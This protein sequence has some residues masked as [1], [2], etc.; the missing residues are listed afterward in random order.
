MLRSLSILAASAVSA[1][2]VNNCDVSSPTGSTEEVTMLQMRTQFSSE[3][4]KA[5]LETEAET[6][7]DALQMSS[8]SSLATGKVVDTTFG[9]EEHSEVN[10]ETEED[11]MED[12][13]EVAESEFV[14]HR[15]V[16]SQNKLTAK[17]ESSRRRR[18]QPQG[19]APVFD[20]P[21]LPPFS[22][23]AGLPERLQ[24][25]RLTKVSL[26]YDTYGHIGGVCMNGAE[27]GYYYGAPRN[28]GSATGESSLWVIHLQG[29]GACTTEGRCNDEVVKIPEKFER[30]SRAPPSTALSTKPENPWRDAHHVYLPYCTEDLWAGQVVTPTNGS[31]CGDCCDQIGQPDYD[32]NCVD[33]WGYHFSG[34]LLFKNIIHH[35]LSTEPASRDMTQVLLTGSSAGGIGVMSN[36]DFLQNFLTDL[37]TD[38]VL[39]NAVE[40]KC[41]PQAGFFFPGYTENQDDVLLPPVTFEDYSVGGTTDPDYDLMRHDILLHRR[42]F[43][44]GCTTSSEFQSETW[45]C[46][47]AM[48]IYPH[49]QAPV[50]V[51]QN[52]MDNN[53]ALQLG[54]I[55]MALDTCMKKSYIAYIGRTMGTTATTI[56]KKPADGWFLASCMDHG[57]GIGLGDN[58]TVQGKT[59][60]EALYDWFVGNDENHILLDDCE[61]SWGGPCNPTCT[62]TWE[63]IEGPCCESELTDLCS[64]ESDRCGCARNHRSRL[65]AAGCSLNTVLQMCQ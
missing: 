59:S 56:S 65:A 44:E 1:V 29:G 22:L 9:A 52:K 42:R 37:Q 47:G 58:T 46:G 3:T 41:A 40:V 5:E 61:S 45:K 23:G 63:V 7:E 24:N 50:F 34:H 48:T 6:M 4:K 33:Q 64:A 19:N 43:P 53:W 35:I 20:V 57:R 39:H 15:N 51:I 60:L 38:G 31:A 17:Q 21:G 36:C 49:I 55:P 27:G 28:V 2:A 26:P 62:D 8:A 32:E 25:D 13:E 18:Q 10:A 16:R 11:T 12:A 54:L 30:E 14:R